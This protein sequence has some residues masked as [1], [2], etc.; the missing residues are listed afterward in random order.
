MHQKSRSMERCAWVGDLQN[1]FPV[2]RVGTVVLNSADFFTR[3]DGHA[4]HQV[5][6]D[7]QRLLSEISARGVATSG[8]LQAAL[9]K[10]VSAGYLKLKHA[11]W[12]QF[13]R[14]LTQWERDTT[15]DC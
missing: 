7:H 3:K 8:Q 12:N 14:H 13:C 6:P 10:E 15:L 11:E 2:H 4:I 5:D 9:G 1:V